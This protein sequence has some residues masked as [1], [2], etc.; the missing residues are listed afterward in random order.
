METLRNLILRSYGQHLSLFI[1]LEV[2]TVHLSL[3]IECA[4]KILLVEYILAIKLQK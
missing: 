4:K 2:F 3:F 1:V